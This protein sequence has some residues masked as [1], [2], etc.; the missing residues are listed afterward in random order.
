[1]NSLENRVQETYAT[2]RTGGEMSLFGFVGGLFFLLVWIEYD[3]SMV[4]DFAA[5]L[6]RTIKWPPQN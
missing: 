5:W 3:G 4:D 1:M 6:K 2:A